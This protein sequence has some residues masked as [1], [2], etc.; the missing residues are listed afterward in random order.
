MDKSKEI[1][2]RKSKETDPL[3]SSVDDNISDI[4]VKHLINMK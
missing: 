1:L 4:E 3:S 2:K